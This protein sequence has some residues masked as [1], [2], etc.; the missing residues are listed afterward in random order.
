MVLSAKLKARVQAAFRNAFAKLSKSKSQEICSSCQMIFPAWM[1]C[2]GAT[3]DRTDVL[4]LVR[5]CLP[6]VS[7]TLI[8]SGF[9]FIFVM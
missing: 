9:E 6:S 1:V 7:L 5:V 4:C 2:D 3:I 8:I